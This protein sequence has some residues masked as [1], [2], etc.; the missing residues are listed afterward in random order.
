MYSANYGKAKEHTTIAAEWAKYNSDLELIRNIGKKGGYTC[1]FCH[2]KLV[3]RSGDIKD[4]HFA[5]ESGT[6]CF[7]AKMQEKQINKYKQQK[8]RESPKHGVI[9]SFIYNELKGQESLHTD[10]F[11]EQ[12][13]AAKAKEGWKYYPDLILKIKNR[14]VAISVLTNVTPTKDQKLINNIKRQN[15]F[16]KEKGLDVVWFVEDREQTLNMHRHTIHLWASEADL[17][18]ETTEDQKW[19]RFLKALRKEHSIFNVFDYLPVGETTDQMDTRVKSLY[20]VSAK[21][22]HVTFTVNRLILD[23]RGEP[24]QGFIINEGYNMRMSTALSVEDNSL[25]LADPKR[26]E[27]LRVDFQKRYQEK[28]ALYTTKLEE[29]RKRKEEEEQQQ[30]KRLAQEIYR[31]EEYARFKREEQE[32]QLAFVAESLSPAPVTA[33]AEL[34]NYSKLTEKEVDR[35]IKKI[36]KSKI[37]AQE[38]KKLYFHMKSNPSEKQK[39]VWRDFQLGMANVTSVQTKTWLVEIECI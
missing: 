5:H 9:L 37:T 36:Y 16:Y 35:L 39:L 25:N 6:S 30:R 13:V 21:E 12:G 10:V 23:R 38:A 15:E 32:R 31:R 28:A 3:I 7:E 17:I 14:E 27:E 33:T 29:E 4:R 26:D 34:N 18:V 22:D 20:Y 8:K 24:Y 2:S 19:T 11:V 1:P